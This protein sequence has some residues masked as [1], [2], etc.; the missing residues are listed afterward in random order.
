MQSNSL[1]INLRYRI[2]RNTFVRILTPFFVPWNQLILLFEDCPHI[3]RIER[4]KIEIQAMENKL[5][6]LVNID[7][8]IKLEKEINLS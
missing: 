5:L 4:R 3:D 1:L 2:T 6:S 7:F 8:V